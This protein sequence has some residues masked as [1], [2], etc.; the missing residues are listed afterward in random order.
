MKEYPNLFSPIKIGPVIFKNRL[1]MAPLTSDNCVVDN[2]PSDQS[3]AF[4]AARARGG[5]AQLTISEVDVDTEFACRAG[6]AFN[7][8]SDP[9]PK[10]WH[11]GAFYELTSA[12]KEHGAV[13]SIELNHTG[14]A[15][16][17][18]NIPGHRNPIG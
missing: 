7:I 9:N 2:R 6:D 3:I 12:I 16:H 18:K 11:S 10:Y 4:H 1:V 14:E 15:N 8:V 17:P 13:A 5:F